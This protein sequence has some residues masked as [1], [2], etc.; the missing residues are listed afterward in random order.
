V[1]LT[2]RQ[3]QDAGLSTDHATTLTL[4]TGGHVVVTPQASPG[5]RSESQFKARKRWFGIQVLFNK[6]ETSNIAIGFN[7]CILVVAKVPV[8]GE[9]L[10]AYCGVLALYAGI[11]KDRGRCLKATF[12]WGSVAPGWGSYRG[13][14]CR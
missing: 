11:L 12:I 2:D 5:D 1:A 14:Y 8:I 4:P 7:A 3:V 13:G 10:A 6:H 9:V